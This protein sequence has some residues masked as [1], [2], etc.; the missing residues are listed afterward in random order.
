MIDQEDERV[1]DRKQRIAFISALI[2]L[3]GALISFWYY[4][5]IFT[6]L[7]SWSTIGLVL[8]CIDLEYKKGW[9]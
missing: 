6:N 5:M 1:L 3:A 8:Y 7:C 9:W 2:M 4:N